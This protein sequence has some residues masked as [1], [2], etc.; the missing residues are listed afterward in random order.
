MMILGELS[1]VGVIVWGG[2]IVG[3]LILKMVSGYLERL[4]FRD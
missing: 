3:W 1:E 4:G 2:F